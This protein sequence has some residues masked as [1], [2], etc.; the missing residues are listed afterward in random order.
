VSKR[1]S[2]TREFREVA[3][4]AVV[5][6]SRPIAEVARELGI[7]AG[8]LGNWVSRYRKDHPVVEEPL[9]Q[10]E[11]AELMS[12]RAEIKELRMKNEF[13]GKASAFFAR[14]YR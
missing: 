10:S 1:Q 9:D 14:N 11:R 7:G 3:V 5:E 2:F 13:L 4:L 12:L 8:T 6:D